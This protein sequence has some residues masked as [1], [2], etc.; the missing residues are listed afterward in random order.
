M[1]ALA[2]AATDTPA[3]RFANV[4]QHLTGAVAAVH[5]TAAAAAA[6]TAVVAA[7]TNAVAA[8]SVLVAAAAAADEVSAHVAA[9]ANN[10]C[11]ATYAID[12]C[13]RCVLAGRRVSTITD[14]I[15][16]PFTSLDLHLP[17]RKRSCLALSPKPKRSPWRGG[18]CVRRGATHVRE[19][20]KTP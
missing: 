5:A 10:H 1:D 9:A 6:A 4:L 2:A 16:G 17:P 7:A 15:T 18:R 13:V 11:S 20:S 19:H 12:R 8:A 3:T 14:L